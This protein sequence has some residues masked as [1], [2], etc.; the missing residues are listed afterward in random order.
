MLRYD[1]NPPDFTDWPGLHAHLMACFA[2]MEELIDPP[3]SLHRLSAE[4]LAE[5][6]QDGCIVL[7]FAGDQIAGCGFGRVR[8]DHLYLD[9]LVVDEAWRGQG[10]LR[11]MVELLAENAHAQNLYALQ[12]QSRV[13]LTDNHAA[14]RAL[15]FKEFTLSL[16]HI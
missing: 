12:L 5:K 2:Y 7:A 1:V 3:S 4:G 6:A 15:G 9:K 14:F 10:I 11:K 13:E 16:I 8:A